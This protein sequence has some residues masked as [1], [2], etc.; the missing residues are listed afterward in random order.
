MTACRYNES[1]NGISERG[2]SG[3]WLAQRIGLDSG[4]ICQYLHSYDPGPEDRKTKASNLLSKQH[5]QHSALSTQQA[6]R[7][8]LFGVNPHHLLF[9]SP[10]STS[11]PHVHMSTCPHVM[12]H[13]SALS[14]PRSLFRHGASA[15]LGNLLRWPPNR[16][17]PEL[18]GWTLA[19]SR[20]GLK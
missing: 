12:S 5:T 4:P 20:V 9:S 2:R 18:L 16:A 14:P 3:C 15:Q 6:D 13:M 17:R 8:W 19:L 1:G 11:S 7:L 10:T